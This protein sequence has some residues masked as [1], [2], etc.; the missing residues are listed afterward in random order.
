MRFARP[1]RPGLC[2]TLALCLPGHPGECRPASELVDLAAASG[3]DFVHE[4]GMTGELYFA[5]MMGSGAALFDYDG[6]GDLDAYLV[7]G[8]PLER[9]AGDGEAPSDR[10]YRN[11]LQALPDGS[12][13]L[14]FTDVT[15]ASGLA[16]LA[17]G[18]GMGVAV[19]DYDGDGHEDLYLTNLGPNQLLRNAGN[20]TF[21]DVTAETGTGDALWGVPAIF[22]DYDRDGRLD[23][24]VGNYVSW[25]LATHKPC[26]SPMGALDYC[27]PA[28]FEPEPDRLFRNL[29]PGKDGVTRFADVTARAMPDSE[30]GA[31]LG[32]LAADFDG[33][34]WLDLYV[35]NDGLPNQ[36]WIN[37]HDGTFH[38]DA[39]LAG[40]SV[41]EKGEAEASM[42]V[43]AGDLDG[44][45]D[46]DLF[47]THLARETNTLYV[48]DGAGSFEDR[49]QESELG[50]PSWP[51]TG[52]GVGLL[53][54]DLDGVQDLFVANGAVTLIEEQVRADS[55]LPLA[56]PNQLFHGL[57]EG[58][59]EEV[60][61]RAGEVF[62]LLEVSRGVAVGDVDNDG[63]PDLL[64]SNNG[65]PARL[66]VAPATSTSPWVGLRLLDATA[67]RPAL[68]ARAALHRREASPL[69]RRVAT[70]GSY[71]SSGDPRALFAPGAAEPTAVEVQ[72]PNGARTRIVSPPPGGYITLIGPP[73]E[74][75]E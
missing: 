27:S 36:L 28:A 55:R 37:R 2:L 53:D 54:Y 9:A 49:S 11:D 4:N 10:L 44:D 41:N 52:F 21:R 18:Y 42:G 17:R 73:A 20:G 26:R 12:R 71:A 56:Q 3:I 38:D 58:R 19:G 43:V 22:F 65:G 35:A 74:G 8:G 32:A 23:L 50:M 6:D 15:E 14:R 66:L 48:N 63:D 68:G 45:G 40:C 60:S 39:L 33:D 24:F 70:D 1:L 34:G 64:L 51:H 31:A 59:F 67:T 7:Q 75:A 5:E 13:R 62:E 16:A 30:P 47:M 61:D 69:W 25:R 72:W 57:G 29:G 46:E